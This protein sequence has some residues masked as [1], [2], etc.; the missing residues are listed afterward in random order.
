MASTS[1]ERSGCLNFFS[2]KMAFVPVQPASEASSISVGRIAESS[3][4]IGASSLATE[5]PEPDSM[6][7]LTLVPLH[8]ATAFFTAGTILAGRG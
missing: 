5:W 1:S 2:S 3:P 7:N 8:L 6:S 4:K